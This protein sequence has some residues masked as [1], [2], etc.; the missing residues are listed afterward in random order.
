MKFNNNFKII[1]AAG[2]VE[3][4]RQV[5]TSVENG[6]TYLFVYS[7]DINSDNI[8]E[9][10]VILEEYGFMKINNRLFKSDLSEFVTLI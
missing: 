4:L 6:K 8:S 9:I 10:N 5:Y 3:I 7:L 1:N 2:N